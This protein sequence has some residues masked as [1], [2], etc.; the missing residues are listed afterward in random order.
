KS[1]FLLHMFPKKTLF[2]ATY[3]PN[4]EKV[5]AI[6]TAAHSA[7]VFVP[8]VRVARRCPGSKRFRCSQRAHRVAQSGY[9]CAAES[10][11][12]PEWRTQG[13]QRQGRPVSGH[14]AS[15][16]IQNPHSG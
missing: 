4:D 15:G 8:I 9:W 2:F 11:D 5:L 10:Q 1:A 6:L 7:L 12:E 3:Y 13:C 14:G 16:G